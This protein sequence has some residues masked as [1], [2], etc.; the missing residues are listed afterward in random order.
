MSLDDLN[1]EQKRQLRKMGALDEQGKP[2]RAQPT[3]KKK[4]ERV[5]I[6]Q[7]LREV[8][9]EMRKVAWPNRPEVKR[10]SIIVII[11]VVVYTALVGGL[12]YVFSEFSQWFY[13]T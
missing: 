1:R 3:A 5:G 4:N 6:R 2:T 12:D 13:S 10:Y 11:T 8:R 9:D 7:Y